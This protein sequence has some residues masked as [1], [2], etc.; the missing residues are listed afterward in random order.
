[1]ADE[2]AQVPAPGIEPMVAKSDTAVAKTAYK[3]TLDKAVR[4]GFS[5]FEFP[6]VATM[7]AA[8]AGLSLEDQLKV[9]NVD[10]KTKA[11]QAAL[12]LALTAAGIVKPNEQTD[13]QLRLKKV[14]DGLMGKYLAQG[15]AKDEAHLKAR[16]KA[17][18][19]LEEEWDDE[20]DD[21]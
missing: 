17:A 18:E 13:S 16:I 14:Y 12:T 9:V 11:R 10:R 8:Q 1:M 5:W 2:T 6:N 20:G 19:F 3:K 15:M 21:E 7:Q 4:Y